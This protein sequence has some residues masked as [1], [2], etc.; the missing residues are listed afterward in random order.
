MEKA[1][2]AKN[3]KLKPNSTLD[4]VPS[5]LPSLIQAYRIQEKAANVG[6]DW[7]NKEQ[8]WE[9]IE[10]ELEEFKIAT[11]KAEREAEMGDL[12]FSLVNFCRHSGI[13]PDDALARTNKKFKQRFQWV[14]QAS[15]AQDKKL[16]ELK[17]HEMEALWQEAKKLEHGKNQ[18]LDER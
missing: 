2:K 18:V 8:V 5:S 14:E 6:F 4:G 15:Q 3:G 16:S 9:K 1:E 13:N 11:D 17:L 7:E 12:L 10:E